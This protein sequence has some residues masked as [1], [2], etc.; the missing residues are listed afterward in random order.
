[1]FESVVAEAERYFNDPRVEQ[2]E[3][4]MGKIDIHMVSNTSVGEEA[5]QARISI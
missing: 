1:M 4:T 5:T 3:K 2:L